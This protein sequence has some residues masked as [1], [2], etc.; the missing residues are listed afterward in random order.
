MRLMQ[1]TA[2]DMEK[3]DMITQIMEVEEG[4]KIQRTFT[5]LVL[6]EPRRTARRNNHA[7][8][9]HLLDRVL[10]MPDD[11]R[12]DMMTVEGILENAHRDQAA[13]DLVSS[14]SRTISVSML[15]P[16]WDSSGWPATSR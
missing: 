1:D 5:R 12:R 2:V 10:Q 15:C 6:Q 8:C 13:P 11:L 3:E 16:N 9:A 14:T 4:M 7:R